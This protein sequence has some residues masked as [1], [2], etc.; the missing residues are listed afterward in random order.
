[1]YLYLSNYCKKLKKMIDKITFKKA[2]YN[3][4]VQEGDCLLIHVALSSFPFIMGGAE[5]VLS[6]LREV[7]GLKG[8]L[9]LPYQFS[10][11]LELAHYANHFSLSEINSFRQNCEPASKCSLAPL[12][13]KICELLLRDKAFIC[14]HPI[15]SYVVEGYLQ[16]ELASKNYSLDFPFGSQSLIAYLHDIK[17]KVLLLGVDYRVATSF[18]YAQSLSLKK[19]IKIEG[20]PI[21]IDKQKKF[22]SYLDFDYINSEKEFLTIG[23]LLEQNKLVNEYCLQKTKIKSFNIRDGFKIALNY[24]LSNN[25]H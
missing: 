4:D 21:F 11:R 10:D 5:T 7:I 24:Y 8:T 13:S 3:V 15:F 2:L 16:N 14:G 23:S 19:A 18:H 12:S 20:C 1:M 17:A 25:N 22:I 9:I 6:A